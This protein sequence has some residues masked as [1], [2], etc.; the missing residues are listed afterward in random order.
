MSEEELTRLL[1]F[2]FIG[3]PVLDIVAA[4]IM[5]RWVH[6]AGGWRASATFL[7]MGALTCTSVAVG[8]TIIGF[9]AVARLV[10]IELDTT[11]R[12]VA[13]FVAVALPSTL[14]IVWVLIWW[15]NRRR[16]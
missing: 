7:R 11:A 1:T 14:S 5:W 3:A 8:T 2:A 6:V 12:L 15:R 9:I 10:E 4:I 16:R 13:S